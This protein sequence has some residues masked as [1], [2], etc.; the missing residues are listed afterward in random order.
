MIN[1]WQFDYRKIARFVL[2]VVAEVTFTQFM[3][4]VLSILFGKIS[5]SSLTAVSTINN[6]MCVYTALITILSVGSAVYISNLTGSQDYVKAS[7]A[8][9]QALVLTL[10][11][12]L[13]LSFFS[14]V[15]NK[16]FVKLIMP[17]ADN[18]LYKEAV[19]Y[20]RI[21]I[22]SI[23]GMAFYLVLLNILRASGDSL[24]PL[25]VMIVVNVT[26]IISAYLFIVSSKMSI[27]GAGLSNVVARTLGGM[28]AFILIMRNKGI[29]K[30]QLRRC[31]KIDIPIIRRIL[32]VGLP[33]AI[34][35]SFI[36]IGYV[37]ANSM[38]VSL[39]T[40][41]ATAFQIAN[42]LSGFAHLF[43]SVNVTV[44]NTF[45]G[46]SIGAGETLRAKKKAYLIFL[47]AVPLV[48]GLYIALLIFQEPLISLYT[49]DPEV[50]LIAKRSLLLFFGAA[51]PAL[52]VNSI[53]PA[54]RAGGDATFVMV[55]TIIGV[56]IIRLPFSYFFA[57][58]MNMGIDGIIIAH[59][60]GLLV[61]ACIGHYRFYGMKWLKYKG[62]S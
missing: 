54:M 20:F 27:I 15:I 32:R 60:L 34:E 25:I 47:A 7:R 51:I 62:N 13:L 58:K 61:R 57:F 1:S 17:G 21:T 28:L 59:V 49:R 18:N 2:P 14:L 43:D 50:I 48:I 12:S 9:E 4:L 10:V 22:Y 16:M 8:T 41:N 33:T 46:Q 52:S 19:L 11:F 31:K 36:E 3:T 40:K 30:V 39:G 37:L 42:S 24:K 6:V 35:G 44:E 29:I 56:W 5:D 26:H 38:V 53:D 45:V 55:E 23:P